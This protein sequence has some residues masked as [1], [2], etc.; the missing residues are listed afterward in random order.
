MGLCAR[1]GA[2]QVCVSENNLAIFHLLD[3]INGLLD[4]EKIEAG[5]MQLYFEYLTA[6][7]LV[8]NVVKSVQPMGA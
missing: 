2:S 6:E 1:M 3:L 5:Q 7:S 4:V 8:D